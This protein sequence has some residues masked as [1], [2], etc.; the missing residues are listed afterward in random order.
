MSRPRKVRELLYV[1]VPIISLVAWLAGGIAILLAIPVMLW[2]YPRVAVIVVSALAFIVAIAWLVHFYW[3]MG[4]LEFRRRGYRIMPAH[5]TDF[6]FWPRGPQQVVYEEFSA[7]GRV[8]R[9]HF[10][11]QI[12][13]DETPNRCEVH[14]PSPERW[15]SKV[16]LWARGRRT[17]IVARID[18]TGPRTQ[19]VDEEGRRHGWNVPEGGSG[20]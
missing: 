1:A 14:L 6:L 3:L 5:V 18:A 7:E 20:S 19:F 17:E 9:L 13:S 8:Q 12:V 15:D 16:P 10:V 2:S 4:R 11:G